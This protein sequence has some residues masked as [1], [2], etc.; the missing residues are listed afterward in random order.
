M[1]SRPYHSGNAR[2]SAGPLRTGSPVACCS[3][4]TSPSQ[5]PGITMLSTP[6]GTTSRLAIQRVVISAATLMFITAI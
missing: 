4:S 1:A 5:R 2:T 6:S 3:V